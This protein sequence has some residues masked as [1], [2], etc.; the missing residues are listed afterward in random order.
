MPRATDTY[1]RKPRSEK[2]RREYLASVCQNELHR[3]EGGEQDAVQG[4]RAEALR[5]YFG[6]PRGDEIDGRSAS[7]SM[8]VAD[9]VNAT[10]AMLVPMLSTDAVVEFEP[11]GEEDETQAKAESDVVNSV[12]IEDNH[13]FIEI[14][15]AV[16]DALLLKNGCMKVRMEER[17][18]QQ[19]FDVSQASREELAALEMQLQPNQVAA[20][21]EDASTLTVTTVQTRFEVGAV[22]IENISYQSG[23]IGDLQQ[24][25]FF[26]ERVRYTRSDLIEM[27]I[28]KKIVDRVQPHTDTHTHAERER[29]QS[30]H[31]RFIAETRDQDIIDCHECWLRVDL[32]G[33]GISERYRVLVANKHVCLEY[34]LVDLLPYSM[35]SPFINPHRLTGESLYDHLKATQDVKTALTRQFLDNVATMNNGRYAYDPSR[36]D[37]KD[38]MS[39]VAGGGIRSR[40]PQAAIVPIMVPDVTSGILQALQY[41]DKRRSERGGASLDMLTADA[42]LVG[43]TAH[44][45]ERQ[46]ASREALSAMMARNL[47]ETLI[48]GIYL[49]THEFLRRYATEPFQVRINGQFQMVDPSQWPQ[50][51]RVNVKTGMSP[52]ERGHLQNVLGQH[53]QL[54]AQAMS[55]GMMNVLA[56]PKTIYRTSMDWL[57]VA[58][59]DNPERLA[60]DPESPEAQQAAAA[61][62]QS[63]QAAN[64][65]QDG[66]VQTQLQL[67]QARIAEDARQHDAEMRHKY[68]D[69]DMDAEIA[70]AKIAGKGVIDLEKQR[71]SNEG[72][73]QAGAEAGAAGIGGVG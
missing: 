63:A 13:G 60:I 14:Q 53:I 1:R 39:P 19:R 16:K 32:D 15:E 36:T 44:G 56:S 4:A 57:R 31:E 58:G 18:T 33:D 21:N 61:Q 9:M 29:D 26:A 54:Q 6:R 37:E 68:Y 59:V 45:I 64:E 30:W 22:P 2:E 62:Q 66:L 38:V 10:L 67:E 12:V 51:S 35:G 42:Q 7:I 73:R 55:Q 47:S 49:L 65:K 24:I 20:M 8:D 17:E 27:G 46:Y 48:R 28:P 11:L 40:D 70:E 52:G 41:E 23:Y 50:R 72:Q 71:V 69:T 34:E 43:E 3:A 5:Y 25:R